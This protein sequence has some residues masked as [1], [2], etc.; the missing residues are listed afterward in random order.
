MG[1]GKGLVY[2]FSKMRSSLNI[3]T[4]NDNLFDCKLNI[5]WSHADIIDVQCS[6]L[7]WPSAYRS[8]GTRV[9]F[10]YSIDN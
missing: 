9:P 8:V 3:L 7:S 5:T 2:R 1:K 6:V 4:M 10:V